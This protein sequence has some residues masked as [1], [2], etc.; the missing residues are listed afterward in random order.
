MI[1]NM[2]LIIL[3][4]AVCIT[5]SL[6]GQVGTKVRIEL[7]GST[8]LDDKEEEQFEFQFYYQITG[9]LE[10]P[11][12][13]SYS[14]FINAR[15]SKKGAFNKDA[16]SN[17]I[18]YYTGLD[19]GLSINRKGSSRFTK[20]E[21]GVYSDVLLD[22]YHRSWHPMYGYKFKSLDVGLL[23]RTRLLRITFRRIELQAF[24]AGSYGIVSIYENSYCGTCVPL[25]T[26][27]SDWTRNVTMG[28]PIQINF[29][30]KM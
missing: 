13:S 19:S 17:L 15:F 4:L 8:I 24:L 28:I 27:D 10:I 7:G 23:L 18:L 26:R 5:F 20:T 2:K 25:T 16:Q 30:P 11:K 14:F 29:N 9:G 1:A 12:S 3:I 21:I 22:T 6:H